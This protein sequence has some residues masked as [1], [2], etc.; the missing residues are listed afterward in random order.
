MK[1]RALHVA[2]EGSVEGVVIADEIG[3]RGAW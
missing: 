2:G 1:P 3:A